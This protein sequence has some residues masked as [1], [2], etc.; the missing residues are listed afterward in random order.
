[1]STIQI[2][3]DLINQIQE[4]IA[5]HD[6]NAQSLDVGIQYLSAII[7]YMASSFP[8]QLEQKRN[9]LQQLYQFSDHVLSEN[10]APAAADAYGVWKPE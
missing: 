10:C 1:M 7:G 9:I 5:K 6:T 4:V 8:G 3:D 2:S